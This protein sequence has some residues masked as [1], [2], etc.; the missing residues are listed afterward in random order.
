MKNIVG[1]AGHSALIAPCESIFQAV[2]TG[3]PCPQTLLFHQCSELCRANRE[4]P[5]GSC[6]HVDGP[7]ALDSKRREH[8]NEESRQE[9]HLYRLVT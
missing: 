6:G 8:D 4:M 1:L 9:S 3:V 5:P 7:V 2:L